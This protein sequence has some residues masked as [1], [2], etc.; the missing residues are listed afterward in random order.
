MANSDSSYYILRY[1]PSAPG[2][3]FFSGSDWYTLPA[4]GTTG[5]LLTGF[6][7]GAGTVSASDTIL[8]AFDKL[9]GNC[10]GKLD[11]TGGTIR[12]LADSTTVF[13]IKNLA[14]TQQLAFDTTHGYLNVGLSSTE[15]DIIV[16]KAGGSG[17][18]VLVSAFNTSTDGNGACSAIND[19]AEYLQIASFGSAFATTDLRRLGLLFSNCATGLRLASTG[20][21]ATVDIAVAGVANANVVGKFSAKG[22]TPILLTTTQRDAISGP[23]EGL[24]IYNTSNHALEFYNGT[25]WKTVATV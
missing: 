22:F 2:M 1:D 4:S 3:Q 15:G 19:M 5:T 25:T 14:G 11:L 23:T 6:V 17:S 16:K 18:S 10:N 20:T 13:Q 9:D 7:S 8:T 21:G 12:P 24:T